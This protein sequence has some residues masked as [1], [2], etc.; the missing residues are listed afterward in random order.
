MQPPCANCERKG[1]GSYHDECK[2][3][4]EFVKHRE[5]EKAFNK[6]RKVGGRLQYL[7]SS[8][9]YNRSPKNGVLK[10]HKK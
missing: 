9:W 3:Y 10:D 7:S 6:R 8:Q 4:K 5:S 1:C 2:K